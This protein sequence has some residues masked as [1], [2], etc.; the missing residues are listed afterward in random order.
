[1]I[2][3]IDFVPMNFGT[4][5]LFTNTM[6]QFLIR[7][8]AGLIWRSL[9][10]LV[11]L[12]LS[13]V[14]SVPQAHGASAPPDFL[15]YQG[16]LA[17]GNGT[18]LAPATPINY[19]VVFRIFDSQTGGNLVWAEVQTV[20]VDKGQF[21]VILGEGSQ[22]ASEPRP[23]LSTVF[24]SPTAS[25]RFMDMTVTIA[26]NA[27]NIA[28]RLRFLPSPYA[29]LATQANSIVS[30]AGTTLL[31]STAN[32]NLN[33]NGTIATPGSVA[34]QATTATSQNLN[35]TIVMRDGAGAFQSSHIFL[36]GTLNGLNA[37]VQSVR[38]SGYLGGHQQGAHLEWN[39][40]NGGGDTYLL[41]QRGQG[42][43]GIV[44][45]EVDGARGIT[46]RMR[47]AHDGRVG[48]GTATPAAQLEVSA[49]AGTVR[50]DI[51]ASPGNRTQLFFKEGGLLKSALT[52]NPSSQTLHFYNNG[53]DGM[54][55]NSLGGVGINSMPTGALQVNGNATNR[56]S[57]GTAVF[58][59]SDIQGGGVPSHIQYGPRGDWYI[60]SAARHGFVFMQDTGGGVAIGTTSDFPATL[61]VQSNAANPQ[62][63]TAIFT[64]A[65]INPDFKSHIHYGTR[66]DIYWRS[67]AADG[68]VI[69]QDTGGNVGIG[70][71]SPTQA[72]LVVAGVGG[73]DKF[74][75][76]AFLTADGASGRINGEYIFGDLSIKATRGIH[77]EFYRAISDQRIKEIDGVSDSGRDLA[78]LEQVEITDYTYRDYL[79]K[80]NRPIKKVIG[81]QLETV[82][83]QAVSQTVD[84]IP[85]IYRHAPIL[86]GWVSLATTLKKGDRVRLIAGKN[87]EIYEILEVR[88]DAFLTTLQT[89]EEKVFVY[90]REVS[91]FRVVD[92]EAIAMLNVSATQE[93]AK[94]V[95]ALNESQ[96]RIAE[97][98]KAVAKVA[99]LES[100]ASRVDSLELQVAE[101]KAMVTQLAKGKQSA[102]ELAAINDSLARN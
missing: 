10:S 45:G 25:D 47:I 12:G 90:G 57:G 63:G 49:A 29:F 17:D 76:H 53:I 38:A 83:P 26:G 15:T 46:E 86:D 7:I 62:A 88:P 4:Q 54:I 40:S 48:I 91:D 5:Q 70:T 9:L 36:T 28:P 80:G 100:K 37:N 8:Q 18:G 82:Y 74:G 51:N 24:A 52:Y 102:E 22:N 3:L 23:A 56:G 27:L 89:E 31:S 97:L 66:G 19:S 101:L 58:V 98:E 6:K 42:R 13:G 50:M 64:A 99:L 16:F 61:H 35:N 34:N 87:D 55:M 39:H 73:T 43:G 11:I 21:S 65:G 2:Q 69:L 32:G 95:K 81:Q 1:M 44:F 94:Q 72:R 60:R 41:N 93:L 33:V 84:V 68:V 30:P 85:D 79:E 96:A 92:Y 59:A 77:A 67:A 75:A 78:I 20:T 14:V 71:G